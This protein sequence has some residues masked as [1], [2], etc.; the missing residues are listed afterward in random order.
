MTQGGTQ[1]GYTAS[2]T[3][4]FWYDARQRLCRHRAPEFGDEL[5]SYDALDRLVSSSRGE[6]AAS[7][8]AAPSASLATVRSYDALDRETALAFPSGAYGLN[9]V[10]A[11][12]HRA[13]Q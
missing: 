6:G 4:L 9:R 3:R 10:S 12:Y 5:F 13:R 11:R 1:N 8:C 7:G 2:V